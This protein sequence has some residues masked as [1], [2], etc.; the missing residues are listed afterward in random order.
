MKD[1]GQSLRDTIEQVIEHWIYA[2]HRDAEIESARHLAYQAVRNS[3]PEVLEALATL[4][5]RHQA[6]NS[7]QLEDKSLYHGFVRAQQG[8]DTA[9][10]VREYRLLRQVI[11]SALEPDLL[12]GSP[13]ESLRAVYVINDVLD[14]II[15]YS[16]ESYIEARLTELKQMQGQLTLTNQELTR[17]VQAQKDNLSFMAHE[18]KTP[19]NSIIGQSSLLLRQ[20]Q[21]K[22]KAKDT[23]TNLDQIE[24]VLRNSRRLLQIIN[25]TLEIARYNE[26]QIHLNLAPTNVSQVIQDIIEDGLEPL[27]QEKGLALEIDVSQA[28]ASAMS[29]ALRLQQLVTNLVSNAIRY[30]DTG[31]VRVTCRQL[32][33]TWWDIAVADTGIGIAIEER[34]RIFDPYTQATVQEQSQSIVSSG[35]GLAIVQ[36]IVALM[37][38]TIDVISEVGEGSTFTIVLPLNPAN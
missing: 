7:D 16:L 23:A 12:S 3:L 15:T 2:V 19:L 8:Y 20:Q 30:T 36:R 5:S 24:R 25:D 9:E 34:S 4:L 14:E 29:D 28:P 37:N 6:S 35:L 32:D 21:K 22:I 18:L 1:L 26:G 11:L 33:A 17:L 10:I 38:G 13:R 27:A 31:S